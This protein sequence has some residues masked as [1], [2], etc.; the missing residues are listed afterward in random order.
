[1]LGIWPDMYQ[2]PESITDDQACDQA[3]SG[4]NGLGKR[5]KNVNIKLFS[6]GPKSGDNCN[7]WK[8]YCF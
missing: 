8:Y 3:G 1:M 6:M 5:K 4:S 2:A 7:Y